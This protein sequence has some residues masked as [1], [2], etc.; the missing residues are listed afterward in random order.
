MWLVA[1][2]LDGT[3]LR[4]KLFILLPHLTIFSPDTDAGM[5]AVTEGEE[6]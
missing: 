1:I 4:S 3:D 6:S 5:K 2:V